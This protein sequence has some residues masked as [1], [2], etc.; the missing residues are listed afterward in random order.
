MTW[1]VHRRHNF[2]VGL[3]CGFALTGCDMQSWTPQSAMDGSGVDSVRAIP[4]NLHRTLV[5]NSVA[6]T[7]VRQPGIIFGLNDSGHDA[8]L[9]AF[10][11]TGQRRGIWRVGGA[12]NR[13]WE[14][15]ALGPCVPRTEQLDC[16]YI[17][18]TGDNEAR[19]PF[20]TIYR[21][22]EPR[23]SSSTPDSLF[24]IH[25]VDRVDIRYPDHPHDV[26]AMYVTRDGSIFLL[27]KR[28]LLDAARQPR[29]ALV[30]QVPGSFWDS[31]GVATALL[32]DSLPIVP[33]SAPGR[34]VSDAALSPDGK[35]LAVR[36]YGEVQVFAMDSS[37]GLPRRDVA[38]T[39]CTILGLEEHQGEGIAWWWDRRRLLLTSEG[40]NAPLFLISCSLPAA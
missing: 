10:D 31:S 36:T 7:S 5:E 14:S 22:E 23:V 21:V 38:P 8:T 15:A 35:R 20:V 16:L 3:I 19:K 12:T 13:D 28:R 27:T 39:S 37:T 4:T 6:V 2:Y 11:S 24:P 1:T 9:F 25:A 30:F 17:G 26:E 32:V 29:P 34:M 33:G 40:R 18:D